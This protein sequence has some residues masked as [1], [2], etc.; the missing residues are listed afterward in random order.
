LEHHIDV[1]IQKRKGE[2]P[3]DG[4][5]RNEEPEPATDIATVW[6]NLAMDSCDHKAVSSDSRYGHLDI[7]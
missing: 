1:Y 5:P 6:C 3:L 2:I 7:L 4:A